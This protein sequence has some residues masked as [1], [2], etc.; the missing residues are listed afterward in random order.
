MKK[1]FRFDCRSCGEEHEDLCEFEDIAI[2]EKYAK[3]VV[4]G[5]TLKRVMTFAMAQ[6]KG[7][8][9]TRKKA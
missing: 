1:M 5:G 9:F 8:G 7:S 3:C 2:T 4:C 6:F